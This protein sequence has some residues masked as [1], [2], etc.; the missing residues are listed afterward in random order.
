M[1]TRTAEKL[2]RQLLSF[3]VSYDVVDKDNWGSFAKLFA[4][5]RQLWDKPYTKGIKSNKLPPPA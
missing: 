5:D 1:G 3:S 4:N 2:R